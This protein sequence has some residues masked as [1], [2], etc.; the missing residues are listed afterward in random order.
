MTISTTIKG[1]LPVLASGNYVKRQYCG[2]Q[3]FATRE[4]PGEQS[5]DAIEDLQ[6]YWFP[7]KPSA[8]PVECSI[9]VPESDIERVCGELLEARLDQGVG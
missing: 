4:Y 6:F 3:P 2:Y 1:G 8:R 9:E 7:R 5:F